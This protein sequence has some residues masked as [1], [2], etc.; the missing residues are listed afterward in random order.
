[1]KAKKQEKEILIR[2][3]TFYFSCELCKKLEWDSKCYD[4]A[5]CGTRIYDLLKWHY[6]REEEIVKDE[7]LHI[8]INQQERR[9]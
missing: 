2:G 4:K 9:L 3:L 5:K 6:G 7:N 1:M 8:R